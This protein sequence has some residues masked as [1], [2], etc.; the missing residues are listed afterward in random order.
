MAPPRKDG[1]ID[2]EGLIEDGENE[3]GATNV[4]L[5]GVTRNDNLMGPQDW[6]WGRTRDGDRFAP[7][8]PEPDE[9]MFG[10]VGPASVAPKRRRK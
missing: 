10:M 1:C 7:F 5:N 3:N 6:A 4:H 9:G 8:K 2:W